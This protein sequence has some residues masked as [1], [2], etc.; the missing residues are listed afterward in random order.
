M[1]KE[2]AIELLEH[3]A[4]DRDIDRNLYGEAI[5][6]AIEALKQQEIVRCKDCIY[7]NWD[8]VDAPY[9]MT[10]TICWCD[11]H[12]DAVNDNL[13]VNPDIDFCSR[14]VRSKTDDQR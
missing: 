10:K 9:D 13:A 7:Y 12:Y 6:I 3:L 2:Q 11:L 4:W 14:A 8:C 1:D 5:N